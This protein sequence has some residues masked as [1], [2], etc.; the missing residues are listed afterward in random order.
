MGSLRG[1][2]VE[3][4]RLQCDDLLEPLDV[5]PCDGQHTELDA[6]LERIGG[7]PPPRDETQ[8]V[9]ERPGEDRVRHRLRRPFESCPIA[10]EGGDRLPERIPGRRKLRRDFLQQPCRPQLAERLL[11]VARSQNLVELLDE[12][13]GRASGDLVSVRRDR[14]EDRLVDRELEPRGEDDRPQHADGILEKPDV[15]IADT[16]DQ[17]RAEVL[18]SAHV[19]DDRER[20]DVVKKRVD[21]EVAAERVLLGGAV[22]VVPLDQVILGS[23]P[24]R[25]PAFG[26]RVDLHRVA[27][28][29]PG[30]RFRRELGRGHVLAE[31]GDLDGLVSVL[32]VRQPEAPSDD[33]AV[34]K[35][36][37]DLVRMG[38]GPDVEVLGPPVQQ[39]IADAS[40]DQVGDVMVLVQ[41]IQNFERVG[42]DVAAGKCM[43][44]PSDDGRLR[45]RVE[46]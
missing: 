35:Q 16:A 37:L 26:R 14:I 25:A 22:R 32:H 8:R 20:A 15:R 36:L 43:L 9:E 30:V 45:H 28:A 10:V 11:G 19:I 38:G 42:V 27:A 18:E 24:Q 31:G 3:E 23:A 21:G 39:Q 7:K 34:A 44:R 2:Q 46:L 40:A 17:P 6:P 41:S 12:P 1:L 13:R 33:P 29:H 4:T 5:A